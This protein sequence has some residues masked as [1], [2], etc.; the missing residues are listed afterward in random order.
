M[1]LPTGFPPIDF[2]H[3]NRDQLPTTLTP[4]R[5]KLVARA[6][7]GLRT[8]AL[9]LPN[10]PAYTYRPTNDGIEITSGDDAAETVIEMDLESWQGL[11]HELEAPAGLLYARRARCVRGN[12]IDLMAWE[13]ALRAL[14]NGRP[15]YDPANHALTDRNGAALDPQTTFT[16]ASDRDVMAHFLTTAGYLFV[17]DVFR[18]DELAVF[19]NEGQQLQREARPGDKLSWWGKNAAG[20]DVLCRVTRAATKPHLA[21]LPTDARLQRLKALA[22][23]TLVHKRGEGDGVTVIFKHPNMAEGLGDLPWHRDCGMGGHAMMCP[24]LVISIYLSEASRESGE[25][26]MLPGSH[27]A[28]FNAHD[29]RTA[30]TAYA[31]HFHARPGDVSVHYSDT[32]HAAPPPA[33]THRSDYR[34]SAIISF[35][36]PDAHHHRGEHSYNAVLHQRDDGQIE[37]LETLAKRM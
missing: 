7:T 6:A 34:I 31:A 25:L 37:H 1:P 24:T 2:P 35:A 4:T 10:G 27:R 16:L 26:A 20:D 8:L 29:P 17:R 9:R 19:L 18:A 21:T 5:R 14:Y 28:A 12:P 30:I 13:S 3:F 36:R 22:D 23:D 15:P 32:V 33:D 11:V